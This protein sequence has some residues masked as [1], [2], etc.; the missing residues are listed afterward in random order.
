MARG[1]EYGVF[2]PTEAAYVG[3]GD[4]ERAVLGEAVKRGSYL[5]QMDQFYAQL[6]EM[7]KEF[8]ERMAL[9][10]KKLGFEERKWGEELAWLKEQEAGRLG[11]EE[12]KVEAER[13]RTRLAYGKTDAEKRRE[14]AGIF[15][16]P[17]KATEGTVPLSWMTEQMSKLY[18]EAN[19]GGRRSEY[20][21]Y[22][23][24]MD[25]Y[26]SFVS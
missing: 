4:F 19:S 24:A 18:P 22:Y 7:E 25:L 12:K 8:T 13:Y 9:E 20:E 17:A 14:A 5:S 23:Q 2:T 10:E 26:K 16:T 3:P 1:G 6:E 21:D 11:V 15:A